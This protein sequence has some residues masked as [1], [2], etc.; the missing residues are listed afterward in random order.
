MS[1]LAL[2]GAIGIWSVVFNDGPDLA[3]VA[4][5]EDPQITATPSPDILPPPV[6]PGT[7]TGTNTSIADLVPA[8]GDEPVQPLEPD[9]AEAGSGAP[10]GPAADTD[11]AL[12]LPDS[13]GGAVS[14]EPGEVIPPEMLPGATPEELVE[15]DNP[16]PDDETAPDI[17]VVTT[18]AE[19]FELPR[20]IAAAP[21][22]GTTEDIYLA[23]IDPVIE[24]V[25]AVSLPSAKV[26]SDTFSPQTSPAPAGTDFDTGSDGLVVASA[27][28]TLAPGG[29]SV[30]AGRPATL[31]QPRP[32]ETEAQQ[33]TQSAENDA[34]RSELARIRP[35]QRPTDAA[36]RVE[37]LTFNGFTREELTRTRPT[38]R[39][40]SIAEAAEEA[41]EAAAEQSAA[42][43]AAAAAAVASLARPDDIQQGATAP[44]GNPPGP[45]SRYAL[46][47]SVR[48]SERPRS[49]ERDAARIVT[50]RREQATPASA[51]ST[52][53]PA[54]ADSSRQTVRSAG[55]SVA[56]AATQSNAIR[57]REVN[58]IGIY[59]RPN[60]RRALV[61]LSN[62]R[63]VKVEVG[64]RLERGR[65]VAI[66]ESEL[67]YQR[68]GRNVALR[69]PQT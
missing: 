22:T 54:A 62:G 66:G 64:D 4:G 8:P 69:M 23:S 59:G 49:V 39:P 46:A 45:T 56:R 38:Q 31:P 1:L 6:S 34:A 28:G 20:E 12:L 53:L 16:G 9:A 27:E 18:E 47:Q 13:R 7:G 14:P 29:Y 44:A 25:D 30:V 68:G 43:Q 10:D 48:P 58:L 33:A 32:G 60:A 67:V 11:V 19:P 37:R 3:G 40:A 17:A 21:Q 15:D 26:P 2:L 41:E 51:A 65:V 50:Q 57:L 35:V 5:S 52:S 55:G 61:R 24:G 63:Y 36:E 42:V